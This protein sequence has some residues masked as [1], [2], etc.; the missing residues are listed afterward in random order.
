VRRR[1]AAEAWP[2]FFHPDLADPSIVLRCGLSSQMRQPA[3]PRFMLV[4]LGADT[5]R[6]GLI[7]CARLSLVGM[8]ETNRWSLPFR[9]IKTLRGKMSSFVLCSWPFSFCR[10]S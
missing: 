5:Q 2:S 1:C 7:P 4:E 3:I 8:V 6:M 9:K 10:Y